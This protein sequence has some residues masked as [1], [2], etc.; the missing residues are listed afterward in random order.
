MIESK[1]KYTY[2]KKTINMQKQKTQKGER[3]LRS[4][5]VEIRDDW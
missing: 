3:T 4:R 1:R 5:Y 2:I